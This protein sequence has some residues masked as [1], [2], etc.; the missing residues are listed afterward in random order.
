MEEAALRPPPYELAIVR[1][2][3]GLVYALIYCATGENL[4]L[5]K[6]V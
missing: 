2:V 6:L 3:Y 5:I 1:S 4:V